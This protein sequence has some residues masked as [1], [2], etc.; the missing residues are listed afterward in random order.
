MRPAIGA[1]R[2]RR[3]KA[4]RGAAKARRSSG[5]KGSLF[6]EGGQAIVGNVQGATPSPSI[7]GANAAPPLAIE[8]EQP[9]ITMDDLISPQR[10]PGTREG[11]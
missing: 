10:E 9:G 4:E 2:Q 8:Q 7:A 1:T 11:A 5:S 3:H 6:H